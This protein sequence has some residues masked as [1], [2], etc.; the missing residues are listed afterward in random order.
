M[1]DA[2]VAFDTRNLAPRMPG[3]VDAA[4]QIC[5]ALQAGSIGNP[6][7]SVRDLNPVGEALG[8]ERP[9][10]EEAVQRFRRILGKESC[11]GVAVVTDGP[12]PVARPQ[13]AVVLFV[14]HVAVGARRWIVGEIGSTLRIAEGE[15]SHSQEHATQ[16]AQQQPSRRAAS[17]CFQTH[18]S[19]IDQLLPACSD[20]SH[21]D[22]PNFPGFA[23]PQSV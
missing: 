11:G 21:I 22:D 8:C 6:V 14:H 20:R 4:R 16:N 10:M 7:V 9:R 5:V 1:A 3:S 19:I 18:H 2:G 17:P 23:R 15:H 13:P 12:F